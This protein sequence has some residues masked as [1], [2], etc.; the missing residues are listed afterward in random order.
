MNVFFAVFFCSKTVTISFTFFTCVH[1]TLWFSF[2]S[3]FQIL[4]ECS[5][6]YSTNVVFHEFF[7]EFWRVFRGGVGDYLD[8]HSE[9]T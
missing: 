2:F 7:K 1:I 5:V 6:P 8:E 3:H 4:A 9:K